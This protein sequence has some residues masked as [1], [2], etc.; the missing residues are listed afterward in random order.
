[1]DIYASMVA[2]EKQANPVFV[3]RTVAVVAMVLAMICA[4]PLLGNFDQAFQYIQEFTGFFTPG[5]VVIF[6]LGMFWKKTT[7]MAALA[8]AIGSA[9]LSFAFKMLLPTLP[10]IDRVGLVFLLCTA[11]AIVISM[12]Q[13]NRVQEKSIEL[14]D[15]NFS[16]SQ[17]FNV[18]AFAVALILAALYATWW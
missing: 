16:T 17:G 3:G 11:I 7:A 12:A 9:V 6:L 5:I 13:G 8:A 10:F 4:K 15:I 1:M 18:A 2:E 14:A